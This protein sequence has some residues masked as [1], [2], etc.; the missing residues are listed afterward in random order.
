MS[1]RLLYLLA[2][3]RTHHALTG[4]RDRL[5]AELAAAQMPMGRH[6]RRA[7]L[8]SIAAANDPIGILP[9]PVDAS[10]GQRAA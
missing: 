4:N 8:R 2:A 10:G 7:N 9:S 1:P 5:D 6:R 3:R